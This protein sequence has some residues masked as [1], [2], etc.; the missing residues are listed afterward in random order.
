MNLG[1]LV[2]VTWTDACV[3]ESGKRRERFKPVTVVTYGKVV[4]LAK[5]YVAITAE[6]LLG[7]EVDFAYRGI[8]T[9]P[10]GMI[11]SYDVLVTNDSVR[12]D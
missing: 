11:E 12:E 10:L 4:V 5:K 2:A 8:T 1:D 3:A 9:I 7:K 6:E